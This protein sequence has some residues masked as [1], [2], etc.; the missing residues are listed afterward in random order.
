MRCY[1]RAMETLIGTSGY[2]YAPWKG[3][4]YPQ[5]M[6]QKQLLPFYAS[7]FPTVEINNTF[8]N[9]PTPELV[10]SW[11][12]EVPATFRFA[13]KAPQ[14]ITHHLRL[15]NAGE[16]LRELWTCVE[17]LAKKRG[18]L[19]FQLPPNMKKN[20]AVLAAFL[21]E[22]PP[23]AAATFEFR[24]ESWF[25]DE[26]YAL[27]RAHKVALCIADT[28]DLA[29]PIV[30]TTDWGYL[31]LRREDYSATDIRR[32]AK[33]IAKQKWKRAFVYFKHEDT[34][35]GPRFAQLLIDAM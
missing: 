21:D 23:K 3:R 30:A 27:L 18:P 16:P 5:K 11:A 29:T 1:G 9:M 32:W 8:Y 15:K 20:V 17:P 34:A 25:S 13:I 6:P 4:F 31:R 28:D 12:D 2:S 7:H 14:R 22:L 26:V 24:H 33:Q 35:K 10:Q 19:L